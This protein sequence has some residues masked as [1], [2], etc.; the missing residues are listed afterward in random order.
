MYHVYVLVCLEDDGVPDPGIWGVEL[1]QRPAYHA[2]LRPS[3]ADQADEARQPPLRRESRRRRTAPVVQH[4]PV[5][6]QASPD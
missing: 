2:V 3:H 1:L 5:S 4:F 6:T